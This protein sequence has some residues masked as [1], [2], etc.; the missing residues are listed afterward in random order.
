MKQELSILIPCYNYDVRPLVRRLQQRARGLDLKFEILVVDDGSDLYVKDNSTLDIL[1][2]VTY[3][4]QAE[5]MGRSAT[6]NKLVEVSNY[7]NL[8]F[9]DADIMPVSDTFLENYLELMN[10]DYDAICGGI[11]YSDAA[12]EPN[13]MLRYLYGRSRESA[14]A[15]ERSKRSHIVMTSNLLIGKDLFRKINSCLDN[16]YGEDLLLS[17]N[18]SREKAKVCHTDNPV[19]HLGIEDST[20]YLNKAKEAITNIVR[21]ERSGELKDDFTRLQESYK[22]LK[23]GPLPLLNMITALFKKRIE[24]NLLSGRPNLKLFDLYRLKY[25]SDLKKHG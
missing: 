17:Q 9:L 12:P 5:N 11:R 22:R 18:L 1:E 8:L 2:G 14:V 23:N 3:R 13:K 25:Y 16:F 21:L 4:H 20:V 6:R 15:K 7:S 24:K 10:S 19:F